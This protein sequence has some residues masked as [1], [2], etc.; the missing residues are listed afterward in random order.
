MIHD[1]AH[2]REAETRALTAALAV[3]A[4]ADWRL[5]RAGAALS[6]PFANYLYVDSAELLL[7]PTSAGLP[8]ARRLTDRAVREA[9]SDALVVA[10]G[11]APSG[12][13]L[14]LFALGLWSS[15]G[16][17]WTVPVWPWLSRDGGLWFGP[18]TQELEVSAW[19]LRQRRLK[20]EPA[21]WRTVRDH[22]AGRVRAL[23]WFDKV[24]G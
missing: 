6:T 24:L 20:A 5:E 9:R 7:V 23:G 17:A 14:L 18:A 11:S 21:P 22:D 10:C 19:P 3:A 1:L 16:T 2:R 13:P 8:F 4:K 15:T 12:N